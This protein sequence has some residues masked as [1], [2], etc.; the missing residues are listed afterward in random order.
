MKN[1]LVTLLILGL[2]GLTSAFA[3]ESCAADQRLVEHELGATCIP[4]APERIVTLEFSFT[5]ALINL[6]VAPAGVTQD[7][8]PL[9]ILDERTQDIPRV[10]S[11]AAPDLEAIAALNPDLIISDLT[12]HADINTQLSSIAPTL[13][14]NSLR[15][16]YETILEQ[17]VSIGTWVGQA[18]RAQS[19][20]A[21][22]RQAFA[23]AIASSKAN[24]ASLVAGV[25]YP[26]GFS[27]HSKDSFAGS[28]L[29]RLGWENPVEPE[30]NATNYNLS[31]EG[32]AS[33]NPDVIVIFQYERERE[34]TPIHDWQ[35]SRVWS[36]LNAVQNDRVY[37]FD[38]DNWTR[39]RGLLAL[40]AVLSEGVASGLVNGISPVSEYRLAP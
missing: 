14:L 34:Q 8:N 7:G 16:D 39:A 28:L 2:T 24:G 35:Q 31:L 4:L 1:I 25:A 27:V 6:D 37:V 33:L 11:R 22:H 38:R 13:V 18:D 19:L 12:R 17:F 29:A 40:D 10:G 5:D 23:D 15:G 21:D 20:V 3:A 36:Q 32:L 30:G 26:G 9:P